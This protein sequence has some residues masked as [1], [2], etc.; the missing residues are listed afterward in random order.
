MKGKGT[1][2]NYTVSVG[3]YRLIY[4]RRF[5]IGRKTKEILAPIPAITGQ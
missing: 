2:Y 4:A 5:N 3:N 1:E